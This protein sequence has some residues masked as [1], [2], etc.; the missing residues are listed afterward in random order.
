M[1]EI[2]DL[3]DKKVWIFDEGPHYDRLVFYDKKA[4]KY[5]LAASGEFRDDLFEWETEISEQCLK[6][7]LH[8]PELFQAILDSEREWI[9]KKPWE[10]TPY[11]KKGRLDTGDGY[12]DRGFGRPWA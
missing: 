11:I 3:A 4:K 10:K 1:V 9:V 12:I 2:R 7:L 6:D 5:F 8:K